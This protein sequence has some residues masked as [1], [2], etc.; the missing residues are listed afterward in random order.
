MA[1]NKKKASGEKVISEIF[2]AVRYL[3]LHH[4]QHYD[5]VAELFT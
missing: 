5:C 1:P 3:K 2:V 4:K